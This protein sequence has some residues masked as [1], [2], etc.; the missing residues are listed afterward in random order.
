MPLPLLAAGA[1]AARFGVTVA[2]LAPLVKPAIGIAKRWM[3]TTARPGI[4]SKVT[5]GPLMVDKTRVF[6]GSKTGVGRI[7]GAAGAVAVGGIGFVASHRST[8]A[9]STATSPATQTRPQ[10]A[11]TAP[12]PATK[13]RSKKCCPVGTKRMVCFKRGRTKKRKTKSTRKRKG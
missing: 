7:A 2:T 6:G 13:Q 3:K 9:T 11:R 10:P 5:K 12:R 4:G 1:L 8:R